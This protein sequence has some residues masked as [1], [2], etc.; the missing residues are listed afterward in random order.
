MMLQIDR[1]LHEAPPTL[2]HLKSL[3]PGRI[4]RAIRRPGRVEN[5]PVPAPGSEQRLLRFDPPA[6]NGSL[7][8]RT[9]T[10]GK[11]T[12]SNTPNIVRRL[13]RLTGKPIGGDDVDSPNERTAGNES[14]WFHDH[15]GDLISGLGLWS[16]KLDRRESDLDRREHEL[17]R[18]SR[19]LRQNQCAG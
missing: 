4:E 19:F 16:M 11:A 17:N 7:L 2:F 5:V 8:S 10:T 6:S 14:D 13:A 15:A 1:P 12:S 3:A 9:A 18:R